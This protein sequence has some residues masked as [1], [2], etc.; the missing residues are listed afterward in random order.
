MARLKNISDREDK[1][2]YNIDG[3]EVNCQVLLMPSGG[4]TQTFQPQ[5]AG[6]S[7][8]PT[9]KVLTP[10]LMHQSCKNI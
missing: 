2:H 9:T 10:E 4:A 6:E 3:A 1:W 7:F 8:A 5:S